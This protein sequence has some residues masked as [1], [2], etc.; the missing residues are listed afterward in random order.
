MAE[1]WKETYATRSCQT[2]SE[3]LH[4]ERTLLRGSALRSGRV[5]EVPLSAFCGIPAAMAILNSC[6]VTGPSYDDGAAINGDVVTRVYTGNLRRCTG[7]TW[8]APVQR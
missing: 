2:M 4:I 8:L 3:T 5:A 1:L 6:E 7:A